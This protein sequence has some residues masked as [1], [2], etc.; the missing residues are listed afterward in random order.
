MH[1]YTAMS[2]DDLK[3]AVGLDTLVRIGARDVTSYSIKNPDRAALRFRL[4]GSNRHIAVAPNYTGDRLLVIPCYRL[5]GE[6][7]QPDTYDVAHWRGSACFT[8]DEL[9]ETVTRVASRAGARGIGSW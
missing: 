8:P 5:T 7:G 4:G 2:S 3:A 6:P 1:R 9:P